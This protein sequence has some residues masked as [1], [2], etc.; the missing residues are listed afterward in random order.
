MVWMVIVYEQNSLN[1]F[2]FTFYGLR[3]NVV[4]EYKQVLRSVKS[5]LL[6]KLP[7]VTRVIE[8]HDYLKSY[9][10]SED[11]CPT[12]LKQFFNNPQYC[13]W[14]HFIHN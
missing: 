14:L 13:L 4:A 1:I 8:M 10:M 2:T 7:A 3:N 9:F 5:R 6:S 11:K 12:L